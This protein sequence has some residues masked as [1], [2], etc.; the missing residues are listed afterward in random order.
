[1]RAV[2]LPSLLLLLSCSLPSSTLAQV[3]LDDFWAGKAHF[4][5]V[6]EITFGNSD[7]GGAAESSSWFTVRAG[8][9]YAFNRVTVR[10]ASPLCPSNH[11]RVVVRESRDKGRSWSPAVV[12]VEPG[13]SAHGDGC[14][15][16]DG[17]TFY[18]PNDGIWHML[19]QCLDHNNSGGWSLCHYTRAA[20]SPLGPFLADRSNPVVRGGELWSR[21]CSGRKACPPTVIDE[22]TPDIVSRQGELF[23]VAFHGFDRKTG[24]GYRGVA[25]TKDFR[26]WQITGAGLPG[27][28]TMGPAECARWLRD[29][30][31]VGEADTISTAAFRYTIAEF[32]DRSLLCTRNQQWVFALFRARLDGWPHSGGGGWTPFPGTP[33][34][35]RTWS[36]PTTPCALSYARWLTDGADTYLVYEDWEPNHAYLHRRLLRLVPGGG[37]P[38]QLR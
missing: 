5:Q 31:G 26:T 30:I 8:T 24:R 23:I 25:G 29:C 36:D 1:M 16:L 6:R 11:T 13:T 37:I 3:S 17:S 33:L 14:A 27:D 12:A 4:E 18:S 20:E 34:L 32:M 9:W 10:P 2:A 21:I 19:T 15:V 38:V 28:A 35:R 22:G 7:R